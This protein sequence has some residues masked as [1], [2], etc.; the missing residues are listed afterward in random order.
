MSVSTLPGIENT[1]IENTGIQNTGIQNA[2]VTAASD[3][4]TR[5]Q[6]WL[7]KRLAEVLT[8][9]EISVTGADLESSATDRSG[10]RLAGHPLAVLRPNSIES[11]QAILRIA[12]AAGVVVVPRGA[13]TGLSGGAAVPDG[14]LVL[15]TEN[16]TGIVRI[17]PDNEIAVVQAGVVT[18]DL[19]AAAAEH[20]LMYAPDP[21]SHEIS[22]IGGNIATNAGGLHC[23]KYGV[24]RESVLGLTV[25]LADG[26][27]LRTGKQTIKGVVGYDLTALLVGSEGTLGVVVEATVRLR[28]RPVKTRTAV[29]FFPSSAA[30]AAGVGALIR[31]RVQP[32]VL[33]LLDAGSLQAI[34]RAQG[35]VLSKGTGPGDGDLPSTRALLLAQ[36]DGYGADAEIEVLGAALAAAGGQVEFLED[37]AAAHY[38]WL[39][40]HGRGPTPDVWM[41]GEDVAVPRSA[42]PAMLTAINGIGE[43]YGLDVSVVAHAGDGNLH[44]L[45][46]IAKRPDD[47][48]VPPAVL[49]VAADELVRAAIACGGTISGEHGVGITK[50][51]WLELEISPDALSLQR[52]VK[53]AFD[54]HGILN[55]HTWLSEVTVADS[56]TTTPSP[57]GVVRPYGDER[58]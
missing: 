14:A 48:G 19:D 40:R 15:S 34:D 22:T 2:A 45:F 42:L 55:P 9:A 17:D 44:P 33:E 18:A 13:G 36:T 23:V 52:R 24:T 58:S 11:V 31:A 28:P 6:R 47:R 32:S 5:Q 35:T 10:H 3:Q 27:V 7:L 4:R 38:L 53:A 29:A 25:V 12:S 54:P 57:D 46:S 16:L 8:P 21:A 56:R 51:E 20:G 49:A 30:A 43:R 1:G 37:E 41:I 50:R 26:S 39:R